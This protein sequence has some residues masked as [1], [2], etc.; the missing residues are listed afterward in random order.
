MLELRPNR[1]QCDKPV[2]PASQDGPFSRRNAPFCATWVETVLLDACPS[3]GGGF[4]PRAI[5]PSRSWKGDNF[6][7]THPPCSTIQHRPV[8]LESR[9][10]WLRMLSD[11]PPQE[12]PQGGKAKRFDSNLH[13]Q[14]HKTFIAK[15]GKRT[16]LQR[17]EIARYSHDGQSNGRS[18]WVLSQGVFSDGPREGADGS[19][20]LV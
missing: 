13:F 1:E 8:N 11:L 9:A 4:A 19:I 3:C 2:P 20:N 17:E 5:R 16:D 15:K 6:L 7:G 10:K 18:R 14:G 12:R